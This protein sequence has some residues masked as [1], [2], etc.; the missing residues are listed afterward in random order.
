L[1]E[2]AIPADFATL[3]KLRARLTTTPF[4]YLRA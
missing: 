1:R 2:L 4:P 3:S